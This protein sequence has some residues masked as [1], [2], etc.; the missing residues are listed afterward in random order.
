MIV[1][2]KVS[3]RFGEK[4]VLKDF[5]LEIEQGSSVCLFGES[6]IGKT[7]LIRLLLG[8]ILPDSG[9]ITGVPQNCSAVFQE[10][11]LCESFTAV[12]NI[13]IATGADKATALQALEEL[14]I[15]RDDAVNKPV[16]AFSGGMKRRVSIARALIAPSDL[17]VLD[18]P[19]KGLDRENLIRAAGFIVERTKNKTLIMVSHSEEEIEL[20]RCKKIEM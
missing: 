10:D 7:T 19:F 5:S 14:G 11:R 1:A 6:G 12:R 2:D 3:K 9:K 4:E 15:G 17:L 20:L 8:L 13:Q 16:S 18:E